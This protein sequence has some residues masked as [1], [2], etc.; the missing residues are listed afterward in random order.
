[1]KL[2]MVSEP[3]VSSSDFWLRWLV[4]EAWHGIRA[5]GL[6]F[7]SWFSQFIVKIAV[8]PLC[9]HM[10]TF[11]SPVCVHVLTFSS[12][13]LFH[14]LTFSSPLIR[15]TWVGVLM[16]ISELPSPFHQFVL[17]VALA[18]AWSLTDSMMFYMIRGFQ[19]LQ[20]CNFW[21]YGTNDMN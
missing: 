2:N 20:I 3:R 7:E 21:M 19:R 13:V 18:S 12:L 8:A 5:Q 9:V 1:M 14:V 15:H 6:E 16:C 4:H 10:L 11:S 17:L